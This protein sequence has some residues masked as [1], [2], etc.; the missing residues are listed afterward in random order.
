MFDQFRVFFNPTNKMKFIRM[1][2]LLF[3]I[4]SINC[5]KDSI[6][7]D[8]YFLSEEDVALSIKV[9]NDARAEVGVSNLKWSNSLSEDALEW[10]KNLAEKDEMYHSSNESRPGQG[11][12]LSVAWKT[13][14]GES[15]FSSTPGLD[16]SNSW[17][18]EINDYTYAEIGSDL[19]ANVMIGHYTQMIWSTTTEVGMARAVS[20]SG[21]EYVVARYSPP[22][23]WVGLFPY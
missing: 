21:K 22:G 13:V 9:H 14:G 19:N 5:S 8:G 2:T 3:L 12:N 20:S 15:V 17:Y 6:S 4:F 16:A 1:L 10:A 18:Y 11:E 7:I 23:N